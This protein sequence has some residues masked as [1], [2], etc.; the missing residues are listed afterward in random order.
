MSE[1]GTVIAL[2]LDKTP[3]YAEQ[4]GQLGDEGFLEFN[5]HHF[6]VRDTQKSGC[7]IMHVGTLFGGA[8]LKVTVKILTRDVRLLGRKGGSFLV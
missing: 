7:Y 6:R 5:G 4:G 2:V 8:S 3:F 1:D